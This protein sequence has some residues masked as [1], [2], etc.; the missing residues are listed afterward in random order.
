MPPVTDARLSAVVPRCAIVCGLAAAAD[1]HGSVRGDT[2]GRRRALRYH[3]R[4]MHLGWPLRFAAWLLAGTLLAGC[5]RE[6][7]VAMSN[8]RWAGEADIAARPPRRI[9]L[10]AKLRP[11]D[12]EQSTP[13]EANKPR[14]IAATYEGT[15]AASH[16][17]SPRIVDLSAALQPGSTTIIREPGANGVIV[18]ATRGS[19]INQ[20]KSAEIAERGSA[21]S[22]FSSSAFSASSCTPSPTPPYHDRPLPQLAERP[23]FHLP[24]VRQPAARTMEAAGPTPGPYGGAP[25]ATPPP[26]QMMAAARTLPATAPAWDDMRSVNRGASYSHAG[27]AFAA[28]PPQSAARNQPTLCQAAELSDRAF[29]M[30][31]RG[32]LYAARVDLIQALEL[33][34]QALDAQRPAGPHAAALA[35]GLAALERASEAHLPAAERQQHLA[36]AHNQLVAAA[37]GVPAASQ[38]LYRLGK[39]HSALATHDNDC[40]ALYEAQ[41]IALHQA[42]L[43]VDGANHLAANELGVLLA[44]RGELAEARRLLT[45]SLS[46]Q[47]HAEGWHNL[48]VVHRRLGEEDLA[49]RAE[50]ERQLAARRSPT[51]ASADAVRWVDRQT[52]VASGPRESAAA[53]TTAA[54]VPSS[55]QRR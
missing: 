54:R 7:P 52:F 5:G 28:S 14:P 31:H 24:P 53:S 8:A 39:V 37:A 51:T 17:P 9:E 15:A 12:A 50:Q 42:A 44:R 30:A 19:E 46:I 4:T 16:A 21:Y 3:G 33:I 1:D 18:S 49:R 26:A 27:G 55:A 36:Y 45:H 41:A 25:P 20:Q 38:T 13:L 34:A 40:G 2:D 23:T 32:M 22:S 43:L 29:A 10:P 11:I 47:P 6:N 48:A 35:S